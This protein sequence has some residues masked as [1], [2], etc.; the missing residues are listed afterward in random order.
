MKRKLLWVLTILPLVVTCFVL[1]FM[2]PSIPM[3]YNASSA[4]DRWGSK[5]E[6]LIFP[7]III[8]FSILWEC[9]MTF[10]KKKQA[11][12]S[13]DKEIQGAINNEK[14][15]SITAIVMAIVFG[16]MHY[17]MMYSAYIEAREDMTVSALDFNVLSTLLMGIAVIIFGNIVPKSRLNSSVGVRTIWSME[18]EETWALS[19]RF[20]GRIFVIT[21]ILIIFSSYIFNGN[22]S[23]FVGIGL[24]VIAA[25]ISIYYTYVAYK[26]VKA[27][28]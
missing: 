26:K 9:L 15:V 11:T 10:Y 14:I 18:N 16:I 23:M 17:F 8:I 2:P 7:A 12:S 24:I 19:N 1:P 13:S 27:K 28:Q 22:I 25:S 5:Y 3:H 4:I 21:G 6:N 20:G